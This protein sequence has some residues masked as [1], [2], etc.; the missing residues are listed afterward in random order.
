MWRTA[1]GSDLPEIDRRKSLG[2]VFIYYKVSDPV[3]SGAQLTDTASQFDIFSIYLPRHCF[4]FFLLG[5]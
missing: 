1:D 2:A 3:S 4:K 5:Y